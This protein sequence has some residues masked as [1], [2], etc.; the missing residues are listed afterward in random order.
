MSSSKVK[1]FVDLEVDGIKSYDYPDFVDA[2][3]SSATAVLEDG[4]MRDATDE[5]LEDLT[6]NGV[7]QQMAYEKSF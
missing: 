2:F 3:I 7:A 4:T 1:E 5:E 6:N